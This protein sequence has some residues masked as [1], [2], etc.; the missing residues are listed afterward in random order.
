MPATSP[1]KVDEDTLK[2]AQ[3]EQDEVQLHISCCVC[4]TDSTWLRTAH[5]FT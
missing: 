2:D 3:G 4:E 1:H 5:S